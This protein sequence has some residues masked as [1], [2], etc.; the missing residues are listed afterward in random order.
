[1]QRKQPSKGVS[2]QRIPRYTDFREP[3]PHSWTHRVA[4]EIK[5]DVRAP[6]TFDWLVRRWDG[7]VEA[8]PGKV[9]YIPCSCEWISDCDDDAAAC[10]VW[11]YGA[12]PEGFC[13]C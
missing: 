2:V 12:A 7:Q 4:Y 3:L 5:E 6:E 9:V 11:I 8:P 1:M 13:R 10:V